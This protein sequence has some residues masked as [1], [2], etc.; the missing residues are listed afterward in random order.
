MNR[1]K[2]EIA[3]EITQITEKLK[4]APKDK[5]LL[6]RKLADLYNELAGRQK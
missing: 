6:E 4:T 2:S 5:E 3:K 1:K